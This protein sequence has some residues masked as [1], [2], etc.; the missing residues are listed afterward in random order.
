MKQQKVVLIY[1]EQKTKSTKQKI[2]EWSKNK[3]LWKQLAESE[4]WKLKTKT[5]L[6]KRNK[7]TEEA[8]WQAFEKVKPSPT[9]NWKYTKYNKVPKRGLWSLKGQISNKIPG[10]ALK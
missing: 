7:I 5:M 1:K 6:A 9:Y 3:L 8:T 10:G 4:R 2:I